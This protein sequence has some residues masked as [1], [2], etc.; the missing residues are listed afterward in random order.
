M[1]LGFY[2]QLR[3]AGLR[4]SPT[5]LLSLMTALTTGHARANL[6]VFYH[7]SRS[8]LVKRET[9]YDAF[10][11][12]FAAYFEGVDQQYALDEELLK[13]LEDPQ[14]PR[15]LTDEERAQ[16][17][18]M[19]L[20]TLKREF[21]ARLAEQK[22]RHDGGSKWIGTGG[23]SP[24]GHGGENPQGIRVGGA[25]GGRSAVHT[26]EERRFQNLRSDR[27]LDVRQMGQALRRLRRLAKQ[28]GEPELD[29]EATIDKS[30]K[31]GGEIDLVFA[32][33][34]TN[35]VK[36]LL[37]VDVGG[38]MDP[39][40]ELTERLFAAAHQSSHFK[41]FESFF[42]HNCVYDKLYKDIS[43]YEGPRTEDVL[44]RI[45]RTWTLVLVGDAWM[46]P[47]ELTHD[48][49]GWSSSSQRKTS[50]IDW[51]KQLQSRVKT[52]AWLN[53]EPKRIWTAP[54]IKLVGSVFPMFELTLDGLTSAVDHLRGARVVTP[55]PFGGALW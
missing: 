40:A 26:A 47:Y 50:G 2:Y 51:L 41:A 19:D 29:I 17:Q 7:L 31:D 14:M 54:S 30:A 15:E 8:L 11:Q 39:H 6:G 49:G 43:R 20:D 32:P 13:W 28:E 55:T 27:T 48:T 16:M 35:R 33:P 24:F 10:D 53:P 34:R 22:K 52:S 37:L 12:A 9:H 1:F 25:G 46:S 42:F 3:A 36:V 44:K 45:D 4:P 21:E 23:T 38:S 5:E 18:K